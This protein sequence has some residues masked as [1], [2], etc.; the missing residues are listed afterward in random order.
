MRQLYIEHMP[1]EGELLTLDGDEAHYLGRS[2][3][4]RPG[5]TFRLAASDGSAAG[6]LLEGFNLGQALLRVGRPDPDPEFPVRCALDLCPPKGDALE[7]AIEMAVQLGVGSLRLVRS[8]RTLAVP[9]KGALSPEKIERRLKEAARQC[10]RARL[11]LLEAPLPLEQAL[12]A[13]PEPLRLIMSERGGAPLRSFSPAGP[14]RVLVGPEGGFSAAELQ[15]ASAAGWRA[16][17]LGPR[18]LKTATAVAAALGGLNALAAPLPS[19]D[20]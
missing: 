7:E 10:L 11:P 16:V 6:A 9:D 14:L 15:S 8:E 12:R 1:R 18:P 19:E 4:A 2:L 3:R 20:A 13:A 5:E 17:S